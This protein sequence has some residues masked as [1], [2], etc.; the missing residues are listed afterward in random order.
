MGRILIT[1]RLV[2]VLAC[3]A[4]LLAACTT[5]YQR[6][7]LAGGYSEKKLDTGIYQVAFSGNGYTSRDTVYRSWLYRCAEITVQQGYD[8]FKVLSPASPRGNTNVADFDTSDAIPTKGGG[9]GGSYRA[10]V[11]VYSG[12]GGGGVRFSATAVIQL[13]HGTPDPRLPMVY[14]ARDVIRDLG[15]EVTKV[16]S[17][18]PPS[19]RIYRPEDVFGGP[20]NTVN[21]VNP[22]Y[23]PS[24]T[25][26]DDLK[27]L[28]PA[29]Q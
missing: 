3:S 14:A 11:Y 10:P 20:G 28:L 8:W 7:G 1:R 19:G 24:M 2:S 5:P 9:G 21:P 27:D 12:G 16:A 23:S 29:A 26:L 4:L 18:T 13:F 22:T 25:T 17:N 6:H 15:A